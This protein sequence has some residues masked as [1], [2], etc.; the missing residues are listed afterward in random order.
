MIDLFFTTRPKLIKCIY[1]IMINELQILLDFYNRKLVIIIK[2][3]IPEI[4]YYIFALEIIP[5][6][7]CR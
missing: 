1:K 6:K 5:I 7:Q 3:I 4:L 2:Y